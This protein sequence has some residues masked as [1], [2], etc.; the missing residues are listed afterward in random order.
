MPSPTRAS[1]R[2]Y[3]E[4][5]RDAALALVKEPGVIDTPQNK[6]LMADD[7]TGCVVWTWPGLADPDIPTLG[8][9]SLSDT[10]DRALYDDLLEAVCEAAQAEGHKKGQAIITSEAVL[11]LMVQDFEVEVEPVGRNVKTKKPGYWHITFDLEANRLI[12]VERRKRR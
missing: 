1:I 2:P 8:G 6:I 5:D 10:G 11:T 4:A 7:G 9:T 3:E 12:L